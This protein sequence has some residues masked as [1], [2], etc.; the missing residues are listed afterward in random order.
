MECLYG[1]LRDRGSS[2][3]AGVVFPPLTATNLAGSPEMMHTVE[4]KLRAQGVPATLVQPEAVAL[5]ILDGI[6]RDRFFVRAGAAESEAIF[7]GAISDDY[8]TWNERIVR[9][10]ADAQLTD[11]VPDSY[12]W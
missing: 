9:G 5:M 10:R 3:R 2:L 12:L 1:Q 4:A 6:E 11:G 7:G 8:L